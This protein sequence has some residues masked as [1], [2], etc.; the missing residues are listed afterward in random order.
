MIFQTKF[1]SNMN[2]FQNEDFQMDDLFFTKVKLQIAISV[3]RQ[4]FQKP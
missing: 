2:I 1:S 3:R 4:T